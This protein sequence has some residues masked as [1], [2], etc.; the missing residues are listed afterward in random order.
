MKAVAPDP[1]RTVA[2]PTLDV[3]KSGKAVSEVKRQAD[4]T[5]RQVSDLRRDVEEAKDEAASLAD[6]VRRVREEGAESESEITRRL[7]AQAVALG[8]RLTKALLRAFEA[9]KAQRDLQES[10]RSAIAEIFELS[11]RAGKVEQAREQAR[12]ENDTL[13]QNN[14]VLRKNEKAF[15]ETLNT[16]KTYKKIWRRAAIVAIASVVILVLLIVAH[17]YGKVSFPLRL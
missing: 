8:D 5:S 4:T 11:E 1:A 10:I 7:S 17:F 16:E 14:S 15:S 13:R 6:T 3:Q 2:P 12:L 9:E